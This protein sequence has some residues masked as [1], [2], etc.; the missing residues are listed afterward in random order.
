M[1]HRVPE[2]TEISSPLGLREQPLSVVRGEQGTLSLWPVQ[3]C[4]SQGCCQPSTCPSL[5]GRVQSIHGIWPAED[6]QQAEARLPAG[7]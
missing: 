6:R 1:K 4:R 3:E 2:E 7:K 5:G